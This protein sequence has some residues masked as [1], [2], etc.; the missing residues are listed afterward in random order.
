MDKMEID[1]ETAIILSIAKRDPV[2]ALEIRGVPP[3]GQGASRSTW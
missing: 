1:M 3:P 2:F